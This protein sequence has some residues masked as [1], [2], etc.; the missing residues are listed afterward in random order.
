MKL[1]ILAIISALIIAIMIPASVHAADVDALPKP[2]MTPTSGL[3]FM[4]TWI[5]RLNMVFTFGAENRVAKALHYAG[6][7]LA[8]MEVMTKQSHT[9]NMEKVATQYRYY[10]NQV[11]RNM[12]QAITRN[13]GTAERVANMMAR[14]I[15]IMTGNHSGDCSECQQIR[16]QNMARAEKCQEQAVKNLARMYPEAAVRLNLALI[17]QQCT[18]LN[19]CIDQPDNEQLRAEWQ[20]YAR[21]RAMNQLTIALAAE[22]GL[23]VGMQQ[24][25]EAATENQDRTLSQIQERLQIHTESKSEEPMQNQNREQPRIGPSQR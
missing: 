6:Q 11:D 9:R 10:L 5:Q 8:E 12:E 18:R 4:E 19:N 15:A 3:Y 24:M 20:Q 1:R 14:H 17:E 22:N 7:K 2:G 16:I 21:L 23:G 25:T 13:T